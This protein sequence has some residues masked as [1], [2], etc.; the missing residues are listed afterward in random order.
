MRFRNTLVS[1]V[2]AGAAIGLTSCKNE[3]PP[4]KVK[5]P[6]QQTQQ[7]SQDQGVGMEARA[8]LLM[9]ELYTRNMSG[10][11]Q[12][13][14]GEMTL[15]QSLDVPFR[16]NGMD[17]QY[18]GDGTNYL[19]TTNENPES[20]DIMTDIVE[21]RQGRDGM[22]IH[23]HESPGAGHHIQISEGDSTVNLSEN[24]GAW[25]RTYSEGENTF[26]PTYTPHQ[27]TSGRNFLDASR[28]LFE[29]YSGSE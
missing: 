4:V 11:N 18:L 7:Q 20:L 5:T 12:V 24:N 9:A 17:I 23:Y 15:N 27:Q 1:V 14:I 25:Q 26:E 8:S 29:K 28:G 6:T 2:L 3:E 19:I 21:E 16:M 10:F 22:A 13:N